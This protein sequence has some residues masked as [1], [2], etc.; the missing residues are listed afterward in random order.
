[1]GELSWIGGAFGVGLVDA[2][3]PLAAVRSARYRFEG[4][5][6]IGCAGGAPFVRAWCC[7]LAGSRLSG[8][9]RGLPLPRLAFFL[10]NASRGA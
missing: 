1:M 6:L 8:C 5:D 7:R 4:L 2:R 10:L 3:S 9:L